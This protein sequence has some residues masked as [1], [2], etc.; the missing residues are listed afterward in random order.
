M[1]YTEKKLATATEFLQN[2]VELGAESSREKMM[3]GEKI[4]Y[5][6]PDFEEFHRRRRRKE[7]C[8]KKGFADFLH[9]QAED[10]ELAEKIDKQTVSMFKPKMKNKLPVEARRAIVALNNIDGKKFSMRK[11]AGKMGLSHTTLNNWKKY[12]DAALIAEILV[13]DDFREKVE[14]LGCDFEDLTT[15]EFLHRLR[16]DFEPGNLG[17]DEGEIVKKGLSHEER[18]S[19]TKERLDQ[20][21]EKQD[22]SS[23]LKNYKSKEKMVGL[24][25]S[26]KERC[27]NVGMVY[28]DLLNGE[29]ALRME[30]SS[31]PFFSNLI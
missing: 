29:K 21:K 27:R 24:T 13:S 11:I 19:E 22:C 8:R 9:C 30:N 31:K 6:C 18:L 2:G 17:S 4:R 1:C 16:V 5:N 25:E 28:Q 15:D 23:R 12:Y 26:E 3:G 20:L 7:K 14:N 10:P